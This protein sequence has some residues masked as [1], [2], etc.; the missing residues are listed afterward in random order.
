MEE[1]MATE[2]PVTESQSNMSQ[3][4]VWVAAMIVA[5]AALAY[6]AT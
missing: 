1:S 3:T 6:F 4:L 2:T 5:V